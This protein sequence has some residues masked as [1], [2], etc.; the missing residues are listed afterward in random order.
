M[1][2]FARVN[3][4]CEMIM[5][6]CVYLVEQCDWKAVQTIRILRTRLVAGSVSNI[7]VLQI[8]KVTG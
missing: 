6:R 5:T 2:A 8:A 7:Y 1:C 3:V 4:A